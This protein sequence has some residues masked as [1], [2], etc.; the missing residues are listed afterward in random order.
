MTQRIREGPPWQ[1]MTAFSED[2]SIG[3]LAPFDSPE[4]MMTNL[5]QRLASSAVLLACL[6]VLVF[7][8][9]QIAGPAMAGVWLLPALLFFAFGTTHDVTS[10]LRAGGTSV[11]RR[12]CMTAVGLVTLSPCAVMLWPIMGMTYPADCPI[13]A[14]GWPAVAGVGAAF[15]VI[16]SEMFAYG[17]NPEGSMPEESNSP[18]D[19]IFVGCFVSLYVGIP[20][21]MLVLIRRLNLETNPTWGLC[22]LL[23]MIA[24]TKS[25]DAGAYFAGK[26]FGRHKLIPRLS[27]GKTWEGAA[28]GLITATIVAALC[29]QFLSPENPIPGNGQGELAEQT[30]DNLTGSDASISEPETDQGAPWWGCFVF[31]PVMMLA[32]LLGDLAESLI[33]RESAAKD[34]GN[35]LP[36]LGGVW[37][38][39]DSLLATAMPAFILLSSGIAG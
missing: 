16:A 36:G 22:A 9:L 35:W 30:V 18:L 13:G 27:P 4:S 19:R 26:A 6:V 1:S 8:D 29:F 10:L 3:P 15:L 2:H 24:T 17:R 7:L 14:A 25:A 21:A 23:S 5:Q 34:S 28:G 33:K 32:G 38:V 20:L 37:D 12:A 31:G 11:S 39:S